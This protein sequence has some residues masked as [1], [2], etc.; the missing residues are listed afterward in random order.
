MTSAVENA[1]ATTAQS[2]DVA[3]LLFDEDDDSLDDLSADESELTDMETSLS[4][5][6]AYNY[7]RKLEGVNDATNLAFGSPDLA[8]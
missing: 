4:H 6:F 8:I 3:E 1:T 5:E 7:G 2:S